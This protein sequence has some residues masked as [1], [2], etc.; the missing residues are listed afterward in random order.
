MGGGSW[1]LRLARRWAIPI[2]EEAAVELGYLYQP[3]R[4]S[5]PEVTLLQQGTPGLW[6]FMSGGFFPDPVDMDKL[7]PAEAPK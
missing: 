6:G 3:D 4:Q 5:I 2:H 7:A 1:M